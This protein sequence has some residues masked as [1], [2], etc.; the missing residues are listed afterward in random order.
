MKMNIIFRTEEVTDYFLI[1]PPIRRMKMN[2]IS[3][4]HTGMPYNSLEILKINYD[5]FLCLGLIVRI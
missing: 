5:T 2:S 4:A 3:V 1:T